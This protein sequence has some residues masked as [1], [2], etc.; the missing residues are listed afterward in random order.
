MDTP[1]ERT[2]ENSKVEFQKI[3]KSYLLSKE[4]K[5]IQIKDFVHEIRFNSSGSS[6][7]SKSTINTS[8]IHQNEA[9][10]NLINESHRVKSSKMTEKTK[11]SYTSLV[12]G[13][14]DSDMESFNRLSSA[15]EKELVS[16]M[17]SNKNKLDWIIEKKS[18]TT[19]SGY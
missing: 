12:E 5:N 14:Y 13:Y 17:K 3:N 2:I 18:F 16:F 8:E 15:K 1:K 7:N 6:S 4:D 9:S 11:K 19:S 10:E